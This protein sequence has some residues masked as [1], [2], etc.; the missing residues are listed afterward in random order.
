MWA[1]EAPEV[2]T[3]IPESLGTNEGEMKLFTTIDVKAIA[4]I[5]WSGWVRVLGGSRAIRR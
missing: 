4:L 2:L 3:P 5:T 1:G